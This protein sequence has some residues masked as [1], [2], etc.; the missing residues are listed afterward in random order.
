MGAKEL[1]QAERSALCDV[2][3]SVGPDA[4]TLCEGWTAADLAAHLIVRERDLSAGPGIL[5]PGPFARYTHRRM[6]GVKGR[7]FAAQVERLRNGPPSWFT[8]GPMA[9]ANLMENFIHHEDLLRPQGGEQRQLPTE[10][11]AF[12][13][14]QLGRMGRLYLLRARGFGVQVATPDGRHRRLRG[15]EPA[16]TVTGLPS[17]LVLFFTGRKDAALVELQGNP[18]TIERLRAARLG[19]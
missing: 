17:E 12:L 16:V 10:L 1:L 2:L 18:E 8:L 11:D 4:P 9:G 7:G 6:E 15:G 3:D 19:I 14:K 5:L 13:W